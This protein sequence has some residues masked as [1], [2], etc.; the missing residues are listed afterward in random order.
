MTTGVVVTRG[1]LSDVQLSFMDALWELGD[2]TVADVQRWLE[3]SGR[4]LAPTTVATVLRRLE[5]KG[6]VA[7]QEDG[8]L[9][10]YRAAVSRDRATGPLVDRLTRTLF[11]GDVPALVSHLLDSRAVTRKDLERIKRL[12]DSKERRTK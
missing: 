3:R 8:R 9:F 7:H 1:S 10:R 5:S 11:G 4:K 2:A 6:W 12:I